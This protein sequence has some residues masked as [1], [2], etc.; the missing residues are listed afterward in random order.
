ME[1]F[2]FLRDKK[3]GIKLA[4]CFGAIFLSVAIVGIFVFIL[5]KE[6]MGHMNFAQKYVIPQSLMTQDL[7]LN[8]ALDVNY[9]NEYIRNNDMSARQKHETYQK[10]CQDI[11]SALKPLI[12][13]EDM[14]DFNKLSKSIENYVLTTSIVIDRHQKMASLYSQ[15][16]NCKTEFC[17]NLLKVRSFFE[18]HSG[19]QLENQNRIIRLSE[20]IRSIENLKGNIKDQ[21]AINDIINSVKNELQNLKIWTSSIS[22][23]Q[24]YDNSLKDYNEYVSKTQEYYS[25]KSEAERANNNIA[26]IVEEL[27]QIVNFFN[28]KGAKLSQTAI[29]TMVSNQL[30]TIN[31]FV[32]LFLVIIFVSAASSII[33]HKKV[34]RRAANTLNGIKNISQGDLTQSVKIESHDEFGQMS[35]ALESMTKKLQ[36]VISKFR[37]GASNILQTSA[38]LSQTAHNM[39]DDANVQAAS[40]EEVS[41]SI[42]EMT[43]GINQNTDNAR[44]TEKI[45][46]MVLQSIKQSSQ[47]SQKSMAAMKDIAG[48]ISIIDEIAFQT[49]ILALNAAVEAARAGEQGKGFAVVAAE[50]RKLAERSAIAASEIDKVSKEG[51]AIS[52]NAEHL[53]KKIIP[54]IEKTTDLVREIAAAGAEQNTGIGQI[55][56][57]VQLLNEVTQKYAASAEELAATSYQLDC[58]SQDLSDTV[59]FFKT[60]KND[61]ADK[62]SYKNTQK[63]YKESKS[64]NGKINTN[65]QEPQPPKTHTQ[66]P[67]PAS[68]AKGEL[69]GSTSIAV[70]NKPQKQ[71]NKQIPEKSKGTFID[72]KDDSADSNYEKF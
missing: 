55:N 4:F 48:K 23:P 62:T 63:T 28:T 64:F 31:M 19:N 10:K 29:E 50:V 34:S 33:I 41:S 26:N 20:I 51:V 67:Q 35:E 27:D 42:E 70:K 43:A 15:M 52:E 7:K 9:F 57:A 61:T 18:K 13:N 66:K 3:I 11:I 22:Q 32:I 56:K 45:A 12:Q 25:C 5:S 59:S 38:K 37:E 40:A 58:K 44:Q 30:K 8:I 46:A 17:N 53:L 36:E 47:E 1:L 16:E 21:A 68:E 69:P 65:H 71:Y 6:S 72:M 14:N 54:E 2:G 49:N 60:S 24:L 39:S